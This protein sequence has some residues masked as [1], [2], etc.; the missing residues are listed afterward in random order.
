[1]IPEADERARR[2]RWGAFLVLAV[3][4]VLAATT[5]GGAAPTEQPLV[6]RIPTHPDFTATTLSAQLTRAGEIEPVTGVSLA[7][8]SPQPTE[9]RHA[10]RVPNGDYIVSVALTWDRRPGPSAPEKTETTRSHRVS[11]TGHETLVVL[12]AKGL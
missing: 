6:F 8:P 7:L 1:M 5:L 10:V 9:V 2:R 4:L 11:L 12:D 3:G